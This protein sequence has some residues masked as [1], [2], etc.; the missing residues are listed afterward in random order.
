MIEAHGLPFT[1][2]NVRL[3]ETGELI[4][5]PYLIVEKGGTTFGIISVLAPEHKI[6]TMAA[7]DAEFLVDDPIK[8]LREVIPE[9]RKQAECIVVLSHLGDRPTEAMIKEIEGI[10]IAI[11]GHTFRTYND[12]RVVDKTVLLGAGYTG[13]FVGKA[14]LDVEEGSGKIMAFQVDMISMDDGIASDP[15]VVEQ[16][17]AFKEELSAFKLEMRGKY[18]PTKGSDKEQFLT[19]RSCQKCHGDIWDTLRR[20]EHQS[21]FA[22]LGKKGQSGNPECVVCHVTGYIYKNGYDEEPPFNRLANVQCEACHGYGTQHK[23]DGSMLKMARDSCVECHDKENSP[24]FD[25]AT[26]WEKIKH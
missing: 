9:V 2:A 25:Y 1:S 21:A 13:R 14:V 26:Y 3:A 10:D 22:S 6:I 8:T 17:A 24:D 20:H 11:V 23:R 7:K 16:V 15:A 5:P 4:L 18:K 12:E 19:Q